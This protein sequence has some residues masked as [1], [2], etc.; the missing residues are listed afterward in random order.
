MADDPLA[1]DE[2]A[3]ANAIAKAVNRPVKLIWTREGG[4]PSG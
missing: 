4:H 1:S 3:Q 2:I